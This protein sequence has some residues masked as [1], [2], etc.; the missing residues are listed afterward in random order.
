MVSPE[1]V[2]IISY[3]TDCSYVSRNIYIYI[4]IYV[5]TYIYDNNE[6][7]AMGLKESKE[8]YMGGFGRR[9]VKR[10]IA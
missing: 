9:K 8:G 5:N 7:G 1:N 4:Y 6:K 2:H 3:I 10:E